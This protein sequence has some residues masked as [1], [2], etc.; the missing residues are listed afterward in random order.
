[1]TN[2][3]RV[4]GDKEKTTKGGVREEGVCVEGRNKEEVG[5]VANSVLIIKTKTMH[6]HSIRIQIFYYV[7]L[8]FICPY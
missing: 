4:L 8:S 6:V 5:D 2:K 3:A 7:S 1:M